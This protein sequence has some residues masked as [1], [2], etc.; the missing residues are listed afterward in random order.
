MKYKQ[1]PFLLLAAAA[2]CAQTP[3][4]WTPE[5][6]MQVR[7]I[8]EVV[9][10]PDGKLVAYTESHA[11][12][13]GEKSEIDTQIFLAAADGSHT[14]QLTRGEKSA[15][16]PEFSPDGRY[17]YF[18]SE[19]S[20]KPN[21]WRIPVDGGEAGMVTDWKGEMG[22]FHVSPDG[23]WI[24]FAGMEPRADEE[25]DKKEKR[26][27]R[28]VD[29]NPKNHSLWI[30]PADPDSQGKRPPRKL[31]ETTYHVQDFDWSPDSHAIAFTHTPTPGADDWTRSDISEVT[32]ETGAVRPVAATGAA[33]HTPRY[34]PD[35]RYLAFVR[36]TD[37]ARWAGMDRIVLLTREGAKS[38]E[39]PPT[40]DEQPD[41]LG[42]SRDSAG[43]LFSEAKGTT[44]LLYE[45]AVDGPAKPVFE[46]HLG[47]WQGGHLNAAASFFAFAA[48]TSNEAPEA[49]VLKL[50][51][52]TPQRVSSANLEMPKLPIGET[53][54]VSWKAADGLDIEGLLTYPVGYQSGK[55]YP[56]ILVIHG[57]PTGVFQDSF[58][59]R[60]GVYPYAT[61]AARGYAVLRANPRGSGG[62]G[63]TFRFANMNDWGGKD[64]ADLMAGVDHVISMGVADPGRLAVMGWSYGGFMT[65]W[66]ITHSH[67]FKAA[68]V[69]AGVTNLW[70][71]AGTSDIPGFLP[72]Y[73]SG[74]PWNSFDGYFNHSPMAF[75]KGV[76]TPTLVLHGEADIRV[77]TSQGYELYHALKR[78]GVTTKM[79]VYPRTPHGPREPKFLLD[80]M[81]RH[82]A[83][84]EQYDTP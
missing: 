45:M 74:D 79:V 1:V 75:V 63:R 60:Y 21:V 80:L 16:A 48:E 29:E 11:V 9:P 57:G 23:K 59:A 77:P 65:S 68:C 78:Q 19:R 12:M 33:E 32:V 69:G 6:S 46:P 73:F 56:M 4:A 43:V 3:T 66:V 47:T 58:L 38:R 24:A 39:L 51:E 5:L 67:R 41:L 62:Y 30:I 61:F 76:T 54:R 50:G 83:W 27:F 37:P 25:K 53:K 84:V 7:P 17:I 81:Q 10:S 70:S 35:G 2:L 28:V 18:S 49:Y 82:L 72:D 71:F 52:S 22:V 26:D 13:E 55:K 34:S 42:W 44:R 64:Y 36:S 14:T 15:T 40:F 31:G 20:G 8:G